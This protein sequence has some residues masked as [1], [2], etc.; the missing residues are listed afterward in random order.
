MERHCYNGRIIAEF[1]KNHPKIEKVY[2]PG[3][4]MH[5][6][7]HVA[8]AQMR[9][10]GGMISFTLKGNQLEDALNLVKKV[11]IFALA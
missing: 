8:K 7:H 1:L 3:F 5:P 4:E 10:F 2:W 9:G 6:N 11:E